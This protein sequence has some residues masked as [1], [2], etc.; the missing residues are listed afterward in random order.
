MYRGF[1]ITFESYLD[2]KY[3]AIGKQ[4]QKREKDKIKES[5]QQYFLEN[6]ELDGTYIMSKWFPVSTY[7]IFLSHSHKDENQAL[8][9]AG[10]LKERHGLNVFVDSS[11]W[12]NCNDLLKL[13]DDKYCLN[14]DKTL[15][16]Y[17]SR[18]YST[19][20]VHMMLMNSLNKMIDNSEALFFL[21]TPNSVSPKNVIKEQTFSPWIYSE[22]ETSKIINKKTP[23][24]LYI[25]TKYFSE[26]RYVALNESSNKN[27][28]IG[29]EVDLGH[30]SKINSYD[31]ETWMNKYYL[32]KFDAL[33][34]L[35]KNFPIKNIILD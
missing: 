8:K 15:Y 6:E 12:L 28:Q 1:N 33:N 10:L 17:S 32:N 22:I 20:H 2:D 25:K 29:Y 21:N 18:N 34:S 14:Q 13:I 30:L 9:I 35:Y 31:F 26:G 19:S 5:F 24:R 27:I 16:D 11:V 7:D 23:E 3:L 4:I